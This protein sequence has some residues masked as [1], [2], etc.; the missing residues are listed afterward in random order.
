M[1]LKPDPMSAGLPPP[2]IVGNLVRA[3][4][5]S[6]TPPTS[7]VIE[8][9]RRIDARDGRASSELRMAIESDTPSRVRSRFDRA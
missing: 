2:E 9:R 6:S 4:P 8:A 1:T 5:E 3:L 7:S